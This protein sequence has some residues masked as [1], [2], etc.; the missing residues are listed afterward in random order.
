VE[1]GMNPVALEEMI[2][3][4]DILETLRW[5]LRLSPAALVREVMIECR[6]RIS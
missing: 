5:L 2:Q 3:P 4:A 1:V 6:L